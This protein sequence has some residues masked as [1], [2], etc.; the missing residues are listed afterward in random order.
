MPGSMRHSVEHLYALDVACGGGLEIE[1]DGKQWTFSPLSFGNARKVIMRARSD[2]VRT[3]NKATQGQDVPR[4]QR[5]MDLNALLFGATVQDV[6]T[7]PATRMY[8][9]EL[10]LRTV[11]T[12]E[13]DKEIQDLL[14][15]LC[16]TE[17]GAALMVTEE[18]VEAVHIMTHGPFTEA[19]LQPEKEGAENPTEAPSAIGGASAT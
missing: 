6:L 7:D 4:L 19:D 16:E 13:T 2:A 1:V 11:H 10:S 15:K 14:E 12:K 9:L 18:I 3:Y 5:T 8:Q 17:D